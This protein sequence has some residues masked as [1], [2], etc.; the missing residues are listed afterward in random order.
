MGARTP[1][2]AC[3]GFSLIEVL[4]SMAILIIVLTTILS[5]LASYQKTYQAEQLKSG[6]E[7]GLNS[8]LELLSQEIGQAGYLGFTP[9]TLQSAVIGGPVAQTVP[10]STVDSLF[11]GEKLVVDTG[12]ASEELITVLGVG[13][14]NVNAIFQQSHSSGAAVTALGVFSTGILSTASGN[15]LQL[16]GDVNADGSLV[17][18][19]YTCNFNAGALTRSV[20]PIAAGAQNTSQPL[21]TGLV[22]NANG[23]P[24]FQFATTSYL[25]STYVTS[26]K[27]TL[28]GQAF[29]KSLQQQQASTMTAALT[30]APRNVVRALTLAQMIPPKT[31][32][33]EPTPPGLPLP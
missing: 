25:G 14:N 10:I 19:Q 15:T 33:L 23:S 30:I 1:A 24:C 11:A 31:D 28:T 21:L 20:T 8:A 2:P 12:L 17:F 22:A 16:Y 3:R 5:V 6:V 9:R 13:T 27:V 18:V 29:L 7:L 32:L 26:V 4:V